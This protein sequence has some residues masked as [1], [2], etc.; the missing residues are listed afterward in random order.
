VLAAQIAIYRQIFTVSM[1]SAKKLDAATRHFLEVRQNV[2]H[3]HPHIFTFCLFNYFK[4][5]ALVISSFY[6]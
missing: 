2:A 4:F 6:P 5:S 3:A 1:A